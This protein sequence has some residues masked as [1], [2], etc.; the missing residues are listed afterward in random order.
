MLTEQD[1]SY[2]LMNFVSQNFYIQKSWSKVAVTLCTNYINLANWTEVVFVLFTTDIYF[3]KI[4]HLLRV[5]SK[6]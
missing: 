3:L 1:T 2:S 6:N 5:Y 4:P